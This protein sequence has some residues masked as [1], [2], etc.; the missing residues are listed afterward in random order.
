[1]GQSI[2]QWR[3]WWRKI[4]IAGGWM[5]LPTQDGCS[6]LVPLSVEKGTTVPLPFPYQTPP[7]CSEGSLSHG[8]HFLYCS[9]L[10]GD[11]PSSTVEG[12]GCSLLWSALFRASDRARYLPEASRALPGILTYNLNSTYCNAPGNPR[13]LS[14]ASWKQPFPFLNWSRTWA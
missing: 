4:V 12:Q 5:T 3:K 11:G 9:S 13:P 6:S 10:K 8:M 2:H 7:H 1:M 14:A